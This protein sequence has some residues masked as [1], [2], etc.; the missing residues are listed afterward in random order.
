MALRHGD[1]TPLFQGCGVKN[2][3][4]KFSSIGFFRGQKKRSAVVDCR[5]KDS[6]AGTMPQ[7]S[8]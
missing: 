4:K 8:H 2:F 1:R 6:I 3:S 5:G 7:K